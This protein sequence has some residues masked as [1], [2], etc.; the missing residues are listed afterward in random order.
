[1]QGASYDG[2][3]EERRSVG[4]ALSGNGVVGQGA[5]KEEAGRKLQDAIAAF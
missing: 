4:R 3:A 1:M 2:V 5:T